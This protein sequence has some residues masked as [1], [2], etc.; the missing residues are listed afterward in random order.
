MRGFVR[1]VAGFADGA[2]AQC[3]ATFRT[4]RAGT[5]QK[6]E[7]REHEN[8]PPFKTETYLRTDRAADA[9]HW[10]AKETLRGHRPGSKGGCP[11]FYGGH[12]PGSNGGC[13]RFTSPFH[14]FPR[15]T[16]LSKTR[17]AGRLGGL[18]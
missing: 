4:L 14:H 12:R 8:F 3:Q 1:E 9:R 15:F 6:A 5:Q 2:S 17:N 7:V 18:T 10:L 11:R 16:P 13:P